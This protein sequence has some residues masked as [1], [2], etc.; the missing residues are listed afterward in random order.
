MYIYI[1]IYICMYTVSVSV[2]GCVC[3]GVW[4]YVHGLLKMYRR[5][6]DILSLLIF[7]TG[8]SEVTQETLVK[9]LIILQKSINHYSNVFLIKD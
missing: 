9:L 7:M 3:G 1:Y 5:L 6:N 8:L 2:R 4:V